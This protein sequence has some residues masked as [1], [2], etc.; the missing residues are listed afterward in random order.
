[1]GCCESLSCHPEPAIVKMGTGHRDDDEPGEG[2]SRTSSH[3]SSRCQ[4][5]QDGSQVSD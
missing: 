2:C 5:G 4:D 1:M 3:E